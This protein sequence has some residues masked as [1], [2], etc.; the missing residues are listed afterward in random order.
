MPP[1]DQPRNPP[2]ADTIEAIA[3]A[4][5]AGSPPSSARISAMSC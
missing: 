1:A 4:T 5:I 3:R 2:D